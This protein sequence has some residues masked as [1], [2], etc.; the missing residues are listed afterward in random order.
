[1]RIAAQL[2]SK[3]AAAVQFA[4]EHQVIH[5]DLKPANVLVVSD[6]KELTV[7]VTDF[8]LARF[9]V[10]DSQPNTKSFTFLGTPS[11]MAPEQAT[12]R[13]RDVGPTA[14]VYSL[15]AVL[16]ELLT[17]QPPIRGESPIETFRLL[18]SSEP[19]SVHR[20]EP[21]ISRDLATICD[22]CLQRDVPKRYS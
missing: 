5:R 11:Y 19:I 3:L 13:P 10:D 8:G 21:R 17:G 14:D 1:P 2:V 20:F 16:H 6:D 7:K 22:K 12:G 15:G 4:H 18:L 9:L